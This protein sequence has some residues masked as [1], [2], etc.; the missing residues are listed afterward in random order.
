M[1]AYEFFTATTT[2]LFIA[3]IKAKAE[4]YGWTIDFFGTYSGHNRLHL[5]NADGAHFEIWYSSST[6]ANIV[7]CTGYSSGSAPTAQPGVSGLGYF[8]GTYPHFIVVGPHAIF[9]KVFIA[10]YYQFMH[11]GAIN[12]KIGTWTGGAFLSHTTS[13]SYTHSLWGLS[14]GTSSLYSQVLI[15]GSWTTRDFSVAGTA[16]AVVAISGSQLIGKMPHAYSG[17]ILP[18]PLLLT[19]VNATTTSYRHPIG[20]A[21]DLRYF[22]PGDLYAQLEELVINGEK[23]VGVNQ[24]EAGVT[25]ANAPDILIRLAA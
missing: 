14:Y 23:W 6:S 13:T 15:N 16:G 24:D 1:A 7:G 12:D 3:N 4:A 11:F 20:Y 25:F 10:T 17:G 5:H 19:L 18:I 21:P 8:Q 22:R 2:D 9:I